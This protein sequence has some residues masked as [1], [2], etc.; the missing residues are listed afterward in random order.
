[1]RSLITISVF[2]L[3]VSYGIQAQEAPF[4]KLD[5]YVALAMNDAKL[6]QNNNLLN[7]EDERDFWIDQI[8]FEKKLSSKNPK[9]Y[10]AYLSGKHIAYARHQKEC[11]GHK[12]S[13]FYYRQA[14]FYA[15]NGSVS[16]QSEPL[17]TVE[18]ASEIKIPK[19][20]NI[21]K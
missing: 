2:L 5:F 11:S 6:E 4:E 18:N 12:H 20:R 7:S 21:P 13:P 19:D 3:L 16:L 14:S 1:M 9:A 8:N 15:V 17:L 10:R